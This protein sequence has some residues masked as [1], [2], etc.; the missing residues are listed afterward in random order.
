MIPLHLP[1]RVTLR[2]MVRT[3][4]DRY[5]NDQT[6]PVEVVT[7][8]HIQARGNT[9]TPEQS[10]RRTPVMMLVP[11]DVQVLDG[12]EVDWSGRRL[13]VMGD[14]TFQLDIFTGRP[15]YGEVELEAVS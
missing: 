6:S 13:R 15:A 7:A 8:A 10:L 11:A 9:A 5:G 1:H 4:T 12:D 14:A 3:G 2:R